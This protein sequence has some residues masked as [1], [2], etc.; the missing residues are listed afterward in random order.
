MTEDSRPQWEVAAERHQNAERAPG[1]T[2][3]DK[4]GD[5]FQDGHRLRQYPVSGANGFISHVKILCDACAD[6]TGRNPQ[7]AMRHYARPSDSCEHP[8]HEFNSIVGGVER[9]SEYETHKDNPAVRGWDLATQSGSTIRTVCPSC[10][11]DRHSRGEDLSDYEPIHEKY[12]DPGDGTNCDD[13]GHDL[14]KSRKTAMRTHAYG[15]IKAPDQVDTL[16][17]ENC[18]VCFTPETLVRTRDGYV[19]IATIEVGDEV[20]SKGGIFRKVIV[21][22]EREYDGVIHEIAARSLV[23]PMRVTPEHPLMAL[24]AQHAKAN[25]VTACRPGK[26]G[27][28]GDLFLGGRWGTQEIRHEVEWVDARDIQVGGFLGTNVFEGGEDVERISVPSQ[29]LGR[30]DRKGPTSFDLTEDF[31]WMVGLY[32][33]E[34]SAGKRSLNFALHQKEVEYIDRL[35]RLFQG[36][37]YTTTTSVRDGH[38]GAWVDVYSTTL[39]TWFPAWLGS[40]S[41]NKALPTEI[42]NLPVERLAHAIQG[43]LDG[44]DCKESEQFGQTSLILALQVAEYFWRSGQSA[45]IYAEFPE[46]KKSV[47]KVNH[48]QS[49]QATARN[50]RVQDT[51]LSQVTGVRTV[52]Y[53]GK[54]YNLAVEGDPSYTVQNVLVH[55]CGESDAYDGDQ[56]QV[57]GFVTPPEMFRDPDL[58]KAKMMDLRADPASGAP[59][60]QDPNVQHDLPPVDPDQVT[61]EGGIEG[62]EAGQPETQDD[63]DGTV[64]VETRGLGDEGLETGQPG[65]EDP[66]APIDPEDLND[67]GVVSPEEAEV[68]EEEQ[69]ADADAEE[70]KASEDA[71]ENGAVS[72]PVDPEAATGHVNQ[73]GEPFTPGPN[74]PTPEQPMEQGGLEEQADDGQEDIGTN[75]VPGEPGDGISDLLCPSCGFTAD[76]ATPTSTPGSPSIPANEGD[77]MMAGDVCPQ[78][79]GATLMST[80]EIQEMTGAPK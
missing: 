41:H 35:E 80:G 57:C 18:P 59:N 30:L 14:G 79:Q 1:R 3:G 66:N 48:H 55:N 19:P 15:E 29:F 61:D 65:Q 38:L 8:E 21:V 70:V 37:G 71:E 51:L 28:Y 17:E 5:E 32:L 77:G 12:V 25:N 16:R 36:L 27:R 13:C 62:E 24:V 75:Q 64:D 39:A 2:G 74:A 78:C 26:C 23:E 42:L 63:G 47:Y 34:G 68:G 50:W 20:L 67:D 33:A 40:G 53:A 31:L 46:G 6:S 44:D 76:A 43:I 73:G 49:A 45:S 54:V 4:P 11:E 52:S 22:H 56:C 58:D 60:D 10:A 69:Q 72:A 9:P 7:H